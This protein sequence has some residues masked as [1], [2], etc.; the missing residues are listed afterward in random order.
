[1]ADERSL[2]AE[3]VARR[4]FATGFRGF[5]QHEVRA[6]L[7]RVA[8]ELASLQ[9]R[10]RSL[11]DRLAAAEARPPA[12]PVDLDD[13][14]ME[15]ALGVETT[16]VI[17]AARE[18]AAE[19]RQRAEESVARMLREANA[20]A[21]RL[22]HEAETVLGARTEEAEAAATAIRAG[23]E[24]EV[25][26]LRAAAEARATAAVDDAQ[27]LGKE[28]VAEA[29]AVRQR[30]L[31]DLARRRA[32]AATQLEQLRAG[33][34]RLLEAYEVV[35]R[36]LDE[37]TNELSVADAEAKLAAEAA[38]LRSAPELEPVD[39]GEPEAEPTGEPEAE[40]SPAEEPP[41]AES[42][43]GDVEP[44]EG[45][46]PAP[47]LS[48]VPA[49]A[50]P[51]GEQRTRSSE[52]E[53]PAARVRPVPLARTPEAA[54]GDE[55]R[56]SALRL[57][58]RKQDDAPSDPPPLDDDVEGVRIIRTT[59]PPGD[60][61]VVEPETEPAP[62]PT[63]EPPEPDP[64]PETEPEPVAADGDEADLAAPDAD[65]DG[66]H[67]PVDDLFARLRA[68]RAASVE[69]AEAVLAV[70]DGAESEQP[71]PA[72]EQEPE[73]EA[74]KAPGDVVFE[75]RDAAVEG[76]ERAITRALKRALADEQNEVLDALRR[77][78]GRPTVE[79]L[80]PSPAEQAARYAAT[81]TKHL[82]AAAGAGA[83]TSD[84]AAEADV[85]A[86]VGA[87]ADEVAAD[88]RARV[89]RA[90]DQAG[91]DVE[92]LQEALSAAYREWKSSRAEPL[93]R[94]AVAG[95]YAAGAYAASSDRALVWVVDP[96]EG[97]C[98]DC[99]DNALAGPTPKGEAFPT[100]QLHPPAHAGCRC[101]VLPAIT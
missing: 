3:D 12:A 19:I 86:L 6:F 38:A 77:L 46:T 69:R 41:T 85:D 72:P 40:A 92:T 30:M 67:A 14:A 10:E 89:E 75:A 84:G 1:M 74:A 48:V 32:K 49:Q 26:E 44:G 18:A 28:M 51:D 37:A 24:R 79:A 34:E 2:S 95:S 35:R 63:P 58:R 8:A 36:T 73:P 16:R 70:D 33:R 50:E 87:F 96:A 56:S 4:Q 81:A 99:D 23:A 22:K 62:V 97:G 88:L 68:D 65:P 100:G 98:P 76:A 20:E 78:K 7:G 5:E 91:G 59:P 45:D 9:E 83:A 71:T 55:R 17:H 43:T 13:A 57:L 64:E 80:L 54:G 101:L 60:D 27:K 82:G 52:P 47:A 29:Q 39:L 66:G 25:E 42:P 11:R 15:A 61:I 90:V 93:G 31:S 94:H 53:Q 21:S